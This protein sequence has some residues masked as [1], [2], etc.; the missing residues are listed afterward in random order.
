MQRK[1]MLT[2]QRRFLLVPENR[3]E[4]WWVPVSTSSDLVP[5]LSETTPKL[6]L[7]NNSEPVTFNQRFRDWYLLNME[8]TGLNP[9]SFVLS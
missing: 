9:N 1:I 2:F 6:W 4:T 5:S 8:Q 3:T 7:S